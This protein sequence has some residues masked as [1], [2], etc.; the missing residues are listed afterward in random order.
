MQGTVYEV[1][2]EDLSKRRVSPEVQPTRRMAEERSYNIL[3][4]KT[5]RR[6]V[7]VCVRS[8]VL[9]GSP[10]SVVSCAVWTYTHTLTLSLT[11]IHPAQLQSSRLLGKVTGSPHQGPDN[12]SE[13]RSQT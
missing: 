11:Q 2:R 13:K 1:F 10:E 5:S 6:E 8:L 3:T 12:S 9:C 4:G 7:C